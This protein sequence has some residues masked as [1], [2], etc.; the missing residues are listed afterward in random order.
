MLQ[1]GSTVLHFVLGTKDL[2][3]FFSLFVPRKTGLTQQHQL[4]WSG[5]CFSVLPKMLK[6]RQKPKLQFCKTK[7]RTGE[8]GK[9]QLVLLM[10]AFLSF[11][12][13]AIIYLKSDCKAEKN[14]D[15]AKNV[16]TDVVPP[17]FR[18]KFCQPF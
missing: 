10:R 13:I 12:N 7:F 14:L 8:D 5:R 6:W 15:W 1:E 3:F 17:P 16:R 18:E 9:Q 2:I 4:V 11:F